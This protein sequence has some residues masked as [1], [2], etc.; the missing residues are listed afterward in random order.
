MRERSPERILKIIE[1]SLKATGYEDVS[2]V[3]LS[4]GDYTCLSP[5]LS[6]LMDRYMEKK[7][8]ISLPSMRL[9]T[10]QPDIIRQIK[11]E[12]DRIHPCA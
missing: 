8:S 1:D 4:T 9:G 12:E 5:L 10:L 7:V 2:L 6:T 11:R 3:S